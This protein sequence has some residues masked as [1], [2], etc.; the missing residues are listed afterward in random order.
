MDANQIANMLAE[1]DES[2]YFKK[3][4]RLN[5]FFVFKQSS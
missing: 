2:G 4:L 1:Q 3:A 5:D